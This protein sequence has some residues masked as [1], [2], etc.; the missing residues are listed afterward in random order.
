MEAVRGKM[1]VNGIMGL[2]SRGKGSERIWNHSREARRVI[3]ASTAMET[4]E[5]K[6]RKERSQ[7][8]EG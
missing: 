4:V 8:R 1:P 2:E 3:G 6:R 7:G 5:R